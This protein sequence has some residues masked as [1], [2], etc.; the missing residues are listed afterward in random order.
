MKKIINTAQPILEKINFIFAVILVFI[1][2]FGI[3]PTQIIVLLWLFSW[4]IQINPKKIIQKWQKQYTLT[5]KIIFFSLILFYFLH[6]VGYLYSE[7]KHEALHILEKKLFML[8]FPLILISANDL[9][10]K[11][12]KIILS[13]F[14]LGNIIASI[15][16]LLFAVFKSI[17]FIDGEII[18]NVAVIK[19]LSFYEDEEGVR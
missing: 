14:V 3:H 18:F 6:L 8:I 2:P 11:H 16:C 1:M 15:T 13:F 12:K 10:T 5:Q 4:I 7:D 17:Y 9:Y 19:K